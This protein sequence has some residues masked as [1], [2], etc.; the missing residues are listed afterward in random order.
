MNVV[1]ITKSKTTRDLEY[2]LICGLL[3]SFTDQT[4]YYR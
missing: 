3:K 2:F 4:I 1:P